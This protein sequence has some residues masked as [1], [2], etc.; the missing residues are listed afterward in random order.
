MFRLSS[1]SNERLTI[2]KR[3]GIFL[4]NFKQIYTTYQL[5]AAML[6][7]ATY[8]LVAVILVESADLS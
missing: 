6:V 4:F 5:V 2:D 3:K 7:V 1:S 8:Q